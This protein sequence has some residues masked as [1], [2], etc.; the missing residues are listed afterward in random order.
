MLVN[1]VYSAKNH[2]FFLFYH[3]PAAPEPAKVYFE[4]NSNIIPTTEWQAFFRLVRE[5]LPFSAEPT[6]WPA[7]VT[8]PIA[9]ETSTFLMEGKSPSLV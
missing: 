1:K 9:M 4:L 2:D 6:R 7:V 3:S 8:D 5:T